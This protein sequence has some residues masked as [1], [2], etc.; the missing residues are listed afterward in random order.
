MNVYT[1][2]FFRHDSMAE[3]EQS[4]ELV[5]VWIAL[6]DEVEQSTVVELERRQRHRVVGEVDLRC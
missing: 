5:N 2:L 3:R 6:F 4:K 1:I